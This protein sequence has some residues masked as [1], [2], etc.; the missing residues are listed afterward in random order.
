[1]MDSLAYRNFACEVL[2]RLIRSLPKRKAVVRI[3]TCD[4]GLPT[5]MMVLAEN[6]DKQGIIVPDELSISPEHGE[7]TGQIQSIGGR[8]IHGELT[9]YEAASLGCAACGTSG[10]VCQFWGLQQLL[11][12]LLKHFV[13]LY[14][15]QLLLRRGRISGCKWQLNLPML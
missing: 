3:A 11:R 14:H 8:F 12:S 4:K 15:I 5:M 10:G 1:M 9:V 6:S 13:Y 7:D 2:G